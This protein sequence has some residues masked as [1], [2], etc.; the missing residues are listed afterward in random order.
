[1]VI[2]A[3]ETYPYPPDIPEGRWAVYEVTLPNMPYH[4]VSVTYRTLTNTIRLS[5]MDMTFE[6]DVWNIPQYLTVFAR[7]DEIN[8]VS[9]YTASFNMSLMS[10]DSNYDGADVDDFRVT[11]EDNDEGKAD[12]GR[13]GN[14]RKE[15]REGRG[16]GK[17]GEGRR[18]DGRREGG[19]EGGKEEREGKG[20]G[21]E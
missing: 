16:E 15:E 2:I 13:E 18:R 7:D 11:V 3:K 6:P 19:K 9:P 4:P 8:S 21:R 17:G 12:G 14:G 10:L 5:H 20:G 1:M